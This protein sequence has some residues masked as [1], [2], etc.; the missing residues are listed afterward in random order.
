VAEPVDR[1]TSWPYEDGE[2]GRYSYA[3]V[4]HPAGEAV[5]AELG[6]L[7]EG[8]ALLFPSGMSAVATVLLTLA[9]PGGTVALA[10]GSYYGT[11]VL[12]RLLEPW[13][14]RLV[15][16]DQAGPPPDDAALVWLEAP[17]NPMLTMPDFEAAA[18]HPAQVVC[19][20]TIATPLAIRPLELGCDVALHSATKVLAGH[21]DVLAGAAVV[22]DD[23]LH[24]RLKKMRWATGA[25]AS[26]DTAFLVARGLKTLAIRVERQT[27]G[28]RALAERLREHPA[29]GA[30]RYPGVG[31]VVSFD[32]AD[33]AAARAVESSTHLIVNATSLGG[34]TSKLESR[35]RWEG[36]R[37]PPGLVRLSVGLEDPDDLWADLDRALSRAAG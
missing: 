37:C 23:G 2:P 9:R 5:E 26:A 12:F 36:E 22:R 20:S 4:A 25:V 24:Q 34:T 21:D 18:A 35:H 7:D 13:G 1:S 32:V 3:R 16:F 33:E 17:A 11:G 6:A 8:Q 14:V 19:D 28:A 29:V 30:V 27:A 31:G 15:E 10:E